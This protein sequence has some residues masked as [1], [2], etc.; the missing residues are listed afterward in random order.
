M[1]EL[2]LLKRDWK[3][4][5]AT[6]PKYE[7]KELYQMLQKKSTSI[8]RWIFIISIIEF[9]LLII[10]DLWTSFSAYNELLADL[11]L[12]KYF[13]GLVILNY[14]IIV[15]FVSLFF[16]NY[17]KINV[18]DNVRK[19]MKNI[20]TA[21]RTVKFY[22]W[23][24]IV[25]FAFSFIL[26]MYKNAEA[27]LALSSEE[28]TIYMIISFVILLFFVLFFLLYYRIVYGILTRKLKKNYNDL[29]KIDIQD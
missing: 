28:M 25:L 22:I 18:T 2:E 3:K 17:R 13:R 26:I 12:E 23:I 6:L 14:M 7:Q 21:R 24:N 4:Q 8:V 27:S 19:L 9:S 16:F 29:K 20:L 5:E 1:D 15:V 11:S 10:L